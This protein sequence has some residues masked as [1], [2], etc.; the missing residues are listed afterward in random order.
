MPPWNGTV[1][2]K[3]KVTGYCMDVS[4]NSTSS[5]A[6]IIQWGTGSSPNGEC[7]STTSNNNHNFPLTPSTPPSTTTTTA[8]T[9]TTAAPTTTAPPALLEVSASSA[10][11]SGGMT[12]NN[13]SIGTAE[14]SGN[15]FNGA[16]STSSKATFT[17]TV[18]EAGTY[19]IQG[20]TIT[21]GGGSDSF[22]VQ[23]DGQPSSGYTWGVS[24]GT[25]YVNDNNGGSDVTV[26]LQPGTHTVT[27][28][29]RED[30]TRLSSLK[31]VKV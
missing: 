21:N 23:V 31:L 29:L 30:G 9:T 15:N 7:K 1:Q 18:T 6:D 14:N 17:F 11:L 19:K 8:P 27:I 5:G 20:A 25:D 12:L 13:G 10:T 4:G 3:N 28:A 2:F 26:S 16:N 22:Y 24:N